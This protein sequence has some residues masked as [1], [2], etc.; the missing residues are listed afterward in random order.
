MGARAEHEWAG[1]IVRAVDALLDYMRV[2]RTPTT[3]DIPRA[4]VVDALAYRLMA[5]GEAAKNLP[6]STREAHPAVPW[7]N[8]I[9]MRDFLA[10]H[11]HRRD[12]QVVVATVESGFLVPLRKAA[13]A[14]VDDARRDHGGDS[15]IPSR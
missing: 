3:A 6:A 14:V 7:S 8:V 13:Q 9:G 1:D 10:H 15:R 2:S 12:D 11:Y 5:I 4:L